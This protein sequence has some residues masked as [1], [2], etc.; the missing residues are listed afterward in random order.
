MTSKIIQ[1][2]E[3]S[4]TELYESLALRFNVFVLEQECLYPEYDPIDYI[5]FHL[6]AFDG[7]ELVGYLRIYKESNDE[8][9]KIGRI[10]I[11]KDHRGKKY[12]EKII[13]QAI[14]FIKKTYPDTSIKISAQ[15]HLKE[16]YQTFGFEQKG[17][18]YPDYGIQHIDMI[19]VI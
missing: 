19:A 16:Y 1:F 2:S 6:L 11:H 5:A 13:K 14:E 12:G 15:E 17:S 10:V 9:P 3:L 18:S 8:Y 4:I 7:K